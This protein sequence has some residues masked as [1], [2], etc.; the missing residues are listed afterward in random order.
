MV[1]KSPIELRGEPPIEDVLADPLIRVVMARDGITSESL[2][3][4]VQDASRRLRP[5]ERHADP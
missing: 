1:R 2:R 5:P 4:L 3:R